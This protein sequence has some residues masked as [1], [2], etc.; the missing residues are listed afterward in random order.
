VTNTFWFM[1]GYARYVWPCFAL[2]LLVLAWNLWSARRYQVAARLRAVR[3]LAAAAA[4]TASAVAAAP[5]G[6]A[7]AVA[8]TAVAG[9]AATPAGAR[10]MATGGE[11]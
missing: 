8:P 9:P 5:A 4:A 1:G 10:A 6:T 2:A 7:P 3:A 11:S